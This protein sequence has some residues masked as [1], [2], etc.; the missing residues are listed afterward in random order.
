[1]MTRIHSN[2]GG[3]TLIE[4]VTVIVVLG[5]L[6]VFTL[7]FLDNAV[8]TYVMAKDQETLYSEGTYIMERVARELNDAQTISAPVSVGIAEH[9]LKFNKPHPSAAEITFTLTGSRTLTMNGELIGKNIKTFDVTKNAAVAGSALNQSITVLLELN[10]L[11]DATVPTFSLKTTI[12]PN[13]YNSGYVDR[14]FNGD[15]YENIK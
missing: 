1:M 13:N 4:L 6:S 12:I 8:K 15:Y 7:S 9:T 10:N 5:I 11:N 14:S 2:S 3:F